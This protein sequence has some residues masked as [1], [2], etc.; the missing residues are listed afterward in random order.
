VYGS[1]GEA[2][3]DAVRL[4]LVGDIT[5]I[6]YTPRA[7]TRQV[8]VRIPEIALRRLK[9]RGYSTYSDALRACVAGLLK[10][11]GYN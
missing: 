5:P 1:V 8:C 4:A 11:W 7:Y 10:A 3:R 2:V 6:N 9:E